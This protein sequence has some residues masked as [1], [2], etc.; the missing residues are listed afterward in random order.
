MASEHY[1]SRMR[2][3]LLCVLLRSNMFEAKM[4]SLCEPQL[5]HHKFDILTRLVL[6]HFQA[7]QMG[8]LCALLYLAVH[9]IALHCICIQH[10]QHSHVVQPCGT[11]AIMWHT[12]VAHLMWRTHVAKPM[13]HI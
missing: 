5:I 13:W 2:L 12:H 8:A 4:A 9:C 11:F 10:L 6:N 7:A 1:S 3:G